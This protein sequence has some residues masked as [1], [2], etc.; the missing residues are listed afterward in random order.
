MRPSRAEDLGGNQAISAKTLL[1]EQC[2]NC[3]SLRAMTQAARA[4]ELTTIEQRR[5]QL[6][7]LD[8]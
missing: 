2:Q 3:A 6:L 7:K 1:E 8:P 4:H 5:R